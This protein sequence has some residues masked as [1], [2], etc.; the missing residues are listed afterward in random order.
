MTPVITIRAAVVTAGDD[1]ALALATQHAESHMRAERHDAEILRRCSD[2][3]IGVM[4]A[5][6][7]TVW[8]PRV[9]IGVPLLERAA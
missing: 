7:G 1:W 8:D 5:D 3:R 9:W 2:T 4:A 6:R